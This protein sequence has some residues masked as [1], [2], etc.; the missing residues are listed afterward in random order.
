MKFDITKTPTRGAKRTLS[1]F[2]DAMFLLL[3]QKPFEDITVQALCDEAA[4]PRATFY[5]YF[6][7]KYDLLNYCWLWLA[8]QIHLDD[9]RYIPHDEALD[10]FVE[11]IFDFTAENRERIAQVL[12]H[13]VE[14][15]Y[16]FS[17][18]RSF[19]N[20]QMS[21]IFQSCTRADSYT[22]PNELLANHYS[23]T[24]LLVWQWCYLKGTPC[25][26]VQARDYLHCLL[27]GV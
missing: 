15:G 8:E 26:K 21:A 14:V 1:A 19:M 2:K 3:A 12:T 13:N 22:V 18:F 11:R 23:N 20:V 5:N 17:S 7:D 4:Y 16:M 6:D 27:G 24:I 25:T 9:Y 10:V